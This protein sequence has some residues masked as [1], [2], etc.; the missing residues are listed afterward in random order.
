MDERE[1]KILII[2]SLIFATFVLIIIL[3]N[4]F[5]FNPDLI[6]DE[7]IRMLGMNPDEVRLLIFL[8]LPIIIFGFMGVALA[9]RMKYH[10]GY[11]KVKY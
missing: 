5:Y 6:N 3:Y 8:G 9:L 2:T 7:A 11:N 4:V 1:K 10:A